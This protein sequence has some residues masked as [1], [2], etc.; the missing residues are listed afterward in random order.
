MAVSLAKYTR[1]CKISRKRNR[2]WLNYLKCKSKLAP[3]SR[4]TAALRWVLAWDTV[5]HGPTLSRS[6]LNEASKMW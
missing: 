2:A 4:L 6:S 5:Y 1:E 3:A